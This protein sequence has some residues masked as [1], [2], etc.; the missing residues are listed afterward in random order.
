[1]PRVLLFLLLLPSFAAAQPTAEEIEALQKKI[2]RMRDSV[3]N[4]PRI[5]KFMNEENTQL[6]SRVDTST[7][8]S[9]ISKRDL[10]K[11]KLPKKDTIALRRIPR[12]IFTTQQINGYL[13]N[14][15]N[16]VA[17]LLPDDAVESAKANTKRLGNDPAKL[18]SAAILALQTGS[19]EEAVVLILDAASR[20]GDE[21]LLTNA[22]AILDMAGLSEAAV[23]VLQTVVRNDPGNAAAWNNLGQAFAALGQH[24]S[25]LYYCGGSIKISPE[26]PEANNTAGQIELIRGNKVSAKAYFENSIRGSFNLSAYRGLRTIMKEKCRITPLI[27]PKVKVPEYFNQFQFKLPKQC[28]DLREAKARKEEQQ[29]FAKKLS[30]VISG[31]KKIAKEAEVRRE[32]K[33]KS[34]QFNRDLMDKAM[35]GEPVV[36]PFQVLGGIMEA[37]TLLAYLDD[38][39][40]IKPFNKNNR[41]QYEELEQQYKRAH[42]SLLKKYAGDD[43][44][45]CCGEGDISCCDNNFCKEMNELKNKYLVLFAQLNEEWQSRNL[46]IERTHIDNFIYW[47]Y[48]AAYDIDDFRVK[49]YNRAADYLTNIGMLSDVKTFEPCGQLDEEDEDEEKKKQDSATV[50]EPECAMAFSMRFW[51]GKLD[52]DCEKISFKVDAGVVF[53]YERNFRLRQQTLSLGVGRDLDKTELKALGLEAGLDVEAVASAYITFDLQGVPTDGGLLGK[54]KGKIGVGFESGQKLKFKNSIGLQVGINSGVAFEPGPLKPLWDK[55][56]SKPEMPIN[57][58]VKIYQPS[59]Q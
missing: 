52:G 24:D 18:E 53:R 26:H 11:L 20:S 14:I 16:S 48:L 50:E 55:I 30:K 34:G 57:P 7:R 29:E 13:A 12:G 17:P 45:E 59:G 47:G 56:K 3:M 4:D 58:K 22:G 15:R 39:E 35:K 28:R 33:F 6:L 25:A 43:D 27:K 8:I 5:K 21:V 36:R 1:M 54:L 51:I 31:F 10:E 19:W 46:H 44:E 41:R 42:D 32:Q 49:F 9:S 23:P 38:K 37:E 2:Q 40:Q